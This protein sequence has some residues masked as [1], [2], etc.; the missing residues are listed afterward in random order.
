M[1]GRRWAAL[2]LLAAVFTMHGLQCTSVAV[3]GTAHAAGP[4]HAAPLVRTG[5]APAGD[6]TDPAVAAGPVDTMT[7]GPAA[8]PAVVDGG[9]DTSP[10]GTG[11]HLWTLCLAV[12]VAGLAVL[13]AVLALRRVSLARH[14]LRRPRIRG[15][16]WVAPPR[17]P[18]LF[19]LCLLRT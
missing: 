7:P 10:H 1:A 12:L 16:G 5:P 18:D 4:A 2:L 13:L 19:T 17:A 14:A 9:P 6:S 8:L 15:P 3:D 11:D